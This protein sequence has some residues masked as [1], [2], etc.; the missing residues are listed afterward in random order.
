VTVTAA[1]TGIWQ[2]GDLT[3]NRL[4]SGAMRLTGVP[5]PAAARR[6]TGPSA[7]CALPTHGRRQAAGS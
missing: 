6:M 7:G 1:T 4:G 3:V 5:S 2:L